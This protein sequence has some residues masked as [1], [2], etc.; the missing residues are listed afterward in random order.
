MG[1]LAED[2]DD[3]FA[4]VSNV[5]AVVLGDL[6]YQGTSDID[7]PLNACI[8]RLR[9]EST[10]LRRLKPLEMVQTLGEISSARLASAITALCPTQNTIFGTDPVTYATVEATNLLIDISA[11]QQI[12][13][14]DFG[15]RK[16]VSPRM[17][18]QWAIGVLD[19]LQIPTTLLSKPTVAPTAGRRVCG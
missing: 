6:A 9:T 4:R 16:E 13:L 5:C 14:P 3:L 15:L 11:K 1:I 18:F 17:T 2:H 10:C 7:V 8:E 12:A 19:L